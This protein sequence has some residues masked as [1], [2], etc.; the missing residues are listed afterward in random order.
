MWCIVKITG[1]YLARMEDILDLYEEASD[2]NR[3]VV[4]IDEG[5]CQLIGD[6]V[7]PIPMRP[8]KP[9]KVDNES[10]WIVVWVIWRL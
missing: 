5:P 4:C 8:G 6:V 10:V 1:E 7:T 9:K 2:Q 3:P